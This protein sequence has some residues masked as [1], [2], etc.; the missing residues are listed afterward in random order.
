VSVS[1]SQ[2]PSWRNSMEDAHETVAHFDGD[3]STSFFAVYDG[4]GG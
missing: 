2:N 3:P 4:H 1:V